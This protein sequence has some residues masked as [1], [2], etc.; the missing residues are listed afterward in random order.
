MP[1]G[2]GRRPGDWSREGFVAKREPVFEEPGSSALVVST[3]ELVA[4]AHGRSMRGETAERTYA[5]LALN[6]Q[7]LQKG[8]CCIDVAGVSSPLFWWI[9]QVCTWAPVYPRI[10]HVP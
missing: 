6:I 4:S 2:R 9:E 10:L 3:D 7:K 5:V 1:T 8:H